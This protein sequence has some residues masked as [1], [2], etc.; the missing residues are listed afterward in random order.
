MTPAQAHKLLADIRLDLRD[1]ERDLRRLGDKLIELQAERL[2][3]MRAAREYEEFIEK[4][5]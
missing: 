4:N 5:D 1:N 2:R 3:L